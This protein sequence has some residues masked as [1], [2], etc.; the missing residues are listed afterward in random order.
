[1]AD[2]LERLTNLLALLLETSQPLS[3]HQI[4]SELSGMYPDGLTARRGAFERDKALLR[5]IGVPIETE[6]VASGS[7]AGQTRYRID[8][9][10]YELEQL[11][12][13]PDEQRALQVAI[14]ATRQ[15]STAAQSALWKL[16][17]GRVEVQSVTAAVLPASSVLADLRRAQ[18][19]RAVVTMT[20][21]GQVREVEPAGLLLREGFWY[22]VAFDR[23]RGER[24]TFR[25]D[26]V[27]GE[28]ELGPPDAYTPL[29]IDPVAAFPTD[30]KMIADSNAPE[31]RA[32]VRIDHPRAALVARQLDPE[33]I[34]E[35]AD[36]GSMLCEVPYRNADAF[37]SWVLG[38]G[39]DAEVIE[40]E[41]TRA[42][43]IAWL[44]RV[45]TS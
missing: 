10:R 30:P 39:P 2:R 1:M 36:D 8:R 27:E 18:Q 15:G 16:G 14:A 17:A 4:A 24:R 20:Y 25:I 42:E 11:E 31:V 12:L 7:D 44:D 5:E 3:L 28:V 45:S 9:R 32:R 33:Q 35:R 6:I 37:R 13:E 19:L 43:L 26:R 23:L 29:E 41:S 22:L 21:L 40:P 38:F 34:I